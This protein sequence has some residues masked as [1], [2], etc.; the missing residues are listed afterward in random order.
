MSSSEEFTE[1]EVRELPRDLQNELQSPIKEV[2]EI[3]Q[4]DE[5]SSS[6]EFTER[7]LPRDMQ[8]ELQPSIKKGME[9]F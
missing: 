9:I 8:N 2:M 7:E 1:R 5:L 6:E 3:C 4:S